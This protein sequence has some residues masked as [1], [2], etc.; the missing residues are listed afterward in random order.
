MSVISGFFAKEAKSL[1]RSVLQSNAKQG[2][3]NLFSSWKEKS[4]EQL[5]KEVISKIGYSTSHYAVNKQNEIVFKQSSVFFREWLTY[6]PI[7]SGKLIK[8][9]ESGQ[10]YFDGELLSPSKKIEIINEFVKQT[11]IKT[12]SLNS[13][14]DGAIKLLDVQDYTSKLFK[15]HFAGWV[16]TNESIIDNF[17]PSLYGEALQTDAKYATLLFKKWIVGTAKRAMEPGIA[18]DGC[19]TMQGP[20]GCG[21]TSLFRE[22]L[23]EPF[24]T[25]TGEMLGNIKNPQKFVE[26]IIKKTILCFDELSVLDAPKVREVFK[27]LLSSRFIDVRLPW[28]RDPARFSLRNSFAAT[29]NKKKFIKD[30]SLSRRLWVIELNN[31]SKINFD[32]F[33]KVKT[34]LWQEAVYLAQHNEPHL[35]TTEEQIAV[36]NYNKKFLI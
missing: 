32:Y 30:P 3:K 19:L 17:L 23:P 16:P 7:T 1:A 2:I 12:A 35:L 34:Q 18:F 11:G 22:M 21:K 24:Q 27:Q 4:P 9:E 15:E 8:D 36:E 31:K 26:G 20:A 5:E 33:N 10:V 25:R 14:F 29:T 28:R 13:H 6:A